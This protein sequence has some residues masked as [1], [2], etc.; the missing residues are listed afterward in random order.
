MAVPC[1]FAP[2]VSCDSASSFFVPRGWM[3]D[4]EY[5]LFLY[6]RV[7]SCLV[8]DAVFLAIKKIDE[9]KGEKCFYSCQISFG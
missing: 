8:H 5:S 7:E 1:L 9:K 3:I 4:E 2:K 6:S